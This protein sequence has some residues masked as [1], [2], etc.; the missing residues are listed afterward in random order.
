MRSFHHVQSEDHDHGGMM[1]PIAGAEAVQYFLIRKCGPEYV[2][3]GSRAAFKLASAAND[4]E[5]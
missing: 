5:P 1:D 3:R 4:F 2:S